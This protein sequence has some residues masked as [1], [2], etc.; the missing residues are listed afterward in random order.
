[1]FLEDKELK[2]VKDLMRGTAKT[3]EILTELKQFFLNE[4]SCEIY[5]ILF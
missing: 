3:D 5:A 4:F 2:Y 1:M